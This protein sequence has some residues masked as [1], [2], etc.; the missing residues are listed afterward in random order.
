MV[1]IMHYVTE[2]RMLVLPVWFF[3]C[4]VHY[5]SSGHP[6]RH[7]LLVSFVV[8]WISSSRVLLVSQ[9]GVRDPLANAP[10]DYDRMC[11]DSVLF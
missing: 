10:H 8:V 11:A 6:E 1:E 4:S 5:S 2:H 7:R 3:R 9:T